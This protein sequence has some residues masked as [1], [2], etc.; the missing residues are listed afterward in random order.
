VNK[1]TTEKTLLQL[2]LPVFFEYTLLMA[3]GVVD[4]IMLSTV[5]DQAVAASGT[6]NTY[7]Y[8]VSMI[9]TIMSTGALAVMTQ[10]IGAKHPE[11]AERAKTIG[12]LFNFGCGLLFSVLFAFG[13][14]TILV[15]LN[16]S[17][18]ITADAA[19]YMSIVGAALVFLSMTNIYSS[20]LR[21]FGH[22]KLTLIG[23]AAANI[24]NIILNAAFL[25]AG[26]GIKGVALATLTARIVNLVLSIIFA[27]RI[28][29]K[30]IE[31]P[32]ETRPGFPE[33]PMIGN[34]KIFRQI[35][36]I[37]LP[38]AV[39]VIVFNLSISFMVKCLNQ[40]DPEGIAIGVYSYC[41]QICNLIYC[42]AVSLSQA[43]GIIVG[44]RVGEG[45]FEACYRETMKAVKYGIA[46]TALAAVLSAF[47]GKTLLGILTD[48]QLILGFV[49]MIMIINIVKEIGRAGNYII[50]MALRTSGD[51]AIT[52]I[53][54]LVTM[55]L[56]AFLGSY[57]L[58]I[59]YGMGVYGAWIGMTLDEGLRCLWMYARFRSRKWMS[60]VLVHAQEA[61]TY[62]SVVQ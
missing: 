12:L 5:S 29:R 40:M 59:K 48:N 58:G 61:D 23:S 46:V 41:N 8:L 57:V 38:S 62:N 51:A 34:T 31:K 14:N 25:A 43:N 60:K 17:Q 13:S 19:V 36:K 10:Y 32:L 47:A 27:E 20:Y 28:K 44:W 55:P 45:R 9:F 56:G 11:V 16:T 24:V 53:M 33:V 22:P 37:G 18:A 52:V 49:S 15:F 3:V 21:S 35:L 6:A 1:N 54:G 4:T 42:V 7:L 30:R 2:F 50:S 26:L 39:E